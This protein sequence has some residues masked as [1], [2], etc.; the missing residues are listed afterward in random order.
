[1]A[2]ACTCRGEE[3][4]KC[5]HWETVSALS[6]DG[7]AGHHHGEGGGKLAIWLIEKEGVE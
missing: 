1:M 6:Y 3:V 7:A 5:Q 4:G 2:V